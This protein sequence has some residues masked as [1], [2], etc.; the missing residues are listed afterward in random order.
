[1]GRKPRPGVMRELR[2]TQCHELQTHIFVVHSL[3]G[4][5]SDMIQIVHMQ[6]AAAIRRNAQLYQNIFGACA[7][8]LTLSAQLALWQMPLN[9]TQW[10]QY[11]VACLRANQ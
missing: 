5:L 4:H 11:S 1:M 2:H 3:F 7:V 10:K 6:V 8:K 9:D